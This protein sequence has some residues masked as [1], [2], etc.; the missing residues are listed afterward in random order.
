MK[1]RADYRPGGTETTTGSTPR[2]TC[3]VQYLIWNRPN[4]F[5]GTIF[6]FFVCFIYYGIGQMGKGEIDI[7]GDANRGT[8]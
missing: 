2:N 4:N 3:T 6:L 5:L 1:D 8:D 7:E